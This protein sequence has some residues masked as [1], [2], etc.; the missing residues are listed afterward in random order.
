MEA[1][2]VIVA[3]NVPAIYKVTN[4]KLPHDR[5]IWLEALSKTAKTLGDH[6]IYDMGQFITPI[7]FQTPVRCAG[8]QMWRKWF[9]DLYEWR[10]WQ[11]TPVTARWLGRTSGTNVEA[12]LAKRFG[13]RQHQWASAKMKIELLLLLGF[14]G[15][16]PEGPMGFVEGV[17]VWADSDQNV[18][19]A[20]AIKSLSFPT[21]STLSTMHI[22]SH[23]SPNRYPE[24]SI[25]LPTSAVHYHLIRCSRH[26]WIG[27]TSFPSLSKPW[28]CTTSILLAV[29]LL[30]RAKPSVC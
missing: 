25:L 27:C 6:W 9:R 4:E 7:T 19:E 1:C 8:R 16:V 10:P 12:P 23:C 26:S 5:I 3:I 29:V 17:R 2:F 21:S 15:P 30:N 14:R 24:R 18:H 22:L 28:S 11:Q 20:L 13:S